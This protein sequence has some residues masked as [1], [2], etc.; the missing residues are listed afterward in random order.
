MVPLVVLATSIKAMERPESWAP[1]AS[2][3]KT[4]FHPAAP[5]NSTDLST[6]WAPTI[7]E[8]KAVVAPLTPPLRTVTAT[9]SASWLPSRNLKKR[10]ALAL[11]ATQPCKQG[12]L[13]EQQVARAHRIIPTSKIGHRLKTIRDSLRHSLVSGRHASRLQSK[14]LPPPP[15]P[16][17]PKKPPRANPPPPPKGAPKPQPALR[18]LLSPLF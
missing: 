2:D 18:H 8:P 3:Q 16:P 5:T 13:R 15:P 14:H 9:K 10:K 11:R 6:S 4:P 12:R 7:S 1:G 17:K